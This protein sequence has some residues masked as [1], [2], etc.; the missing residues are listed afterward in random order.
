MAVGQG[1]AGTQVPRGARARPPARVNP[2]VW[3]DLAKWSL[4]KDEPVVYLCGNPGMIEDVQARLKP[5]GWNFIEERFWKEED[6]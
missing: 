2:L 1:P 3:A 4:P 6:E 5:K